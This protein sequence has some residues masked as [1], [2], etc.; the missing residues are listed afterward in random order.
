MELPQ[1]GSFYFVQ[2]KKASPWTDL[3]T[4]GV[5]ASSAPIIKKSQLEYWLSY[6]PEWTR[7]KERYG[8]I[9]APIVTLCNYPFYETTKKMPAIKTG[10]GR[11]NSTK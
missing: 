11:N 6:S 9:V 2:M 7:Q 10:E 5:G 8:F 1:G 4:V 3:I